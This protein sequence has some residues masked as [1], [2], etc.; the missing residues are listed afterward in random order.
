MSTKAEVPNLRRRL[1]FLEANRCR[2]P[3]RLRTILPEPVILKRLATALRV[4]IDFG[5]LCICCRPFNPE[6][7]REKYS[8]DMIESSHFT[9]HFQFFVVESA[10]GN[11]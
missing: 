9:Q 1:A 11:S 6:K 10:L 8:K 3:G 4:L 7:G 2:F 5:L